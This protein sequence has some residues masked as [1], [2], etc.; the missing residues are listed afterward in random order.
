LGKIGVGVYEGVLVKYLYDLYN[1]LSDSTVR[2]TIWRGKLPI[3]PVRVELFP[4][5]TICKHVIE[6]PEPT[7]ILSRPMSGIEY[8]VKYFHDNPFLQAIAI[9]APLIVCG[10]Y[11]G[12]KR[13][14]EKD[15]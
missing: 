6:N 13:Y 12:M 5:P 11:Y 3:S 10:F 15:E 8:V 14:G 4:W 1:V 2:A 9:A 7:L